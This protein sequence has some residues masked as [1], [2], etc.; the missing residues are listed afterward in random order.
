[1]K[2]G[3]YRV[4]TC[5]THKVHCAEP[6]EEARAHVCQLSVVI[7]SHWPRGQQGLLKVFQI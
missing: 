5:V 4:L 6:F 1:M 7:C 2:L 3:L